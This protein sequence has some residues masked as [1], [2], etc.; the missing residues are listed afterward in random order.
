MYTIYLAFVIVGIVVY[1]VTRRGTHTEGYTPTSE[2][3]WSLGDNIFQKTADE[4]NELLKNMGS[5]SNLGVLKDPSYKK[6][7]Q[8]FPR[9]TSFPWAKAL[10]D[11]CTDEFKSKSLG[12]WTTARDVRNVYWKDVQLDRHFVFQIDLEHTKENVVQQALMYVVVRGVNKFLTGTGEYFGVPSAQDMSMDS[13]M[14]ISIQSHGCLAM[15]GNALGEYYEIKNTMHLMDPF[16]TSGKD[17]QVTQGMRASFSK[18]LERKLELEKKGENL[19]FCFDQV[20]GMPA[21]T[22]EECAEAGGVWDSPPTQSEACPFYKANTNYPNTFG[23]LNGLVC[24]MPKNAMLVGH[25]YYSLE[26][27]RAPFCYNCKSNSGKTSTMGMCCD[28]QKNKQLYPQLETPDY[29][30]EGD[31]SVRATYADMLAQKNLSAV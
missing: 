3:C 12:V 25:R 28:E 7:F 5:Q 4:L 9:Q 10:R 30:F 8:N 13:G 21:T 11:Y 18:D 26:P 2:D 15:P 19:S 27:S 6:T 23:K 24:E 29:A 22:S 14:V 17:L 16:L 1:L 20:A 31:S